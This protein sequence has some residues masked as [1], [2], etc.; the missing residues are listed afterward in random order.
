L[1]V[2]RNRVYELDSEDSRTLAVGG[3]F[4]VVPEHDLDV[5]HDTF[6]NLQDQRLVELVDL[7]EGER[8]LTLTT[9]ET[10]SN[11]T[12]GNDMMSRRRCSTFQLLGVVRQC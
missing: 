11:R 10:C 2:D 3:A 6:D 9:D 5:P 7:G 12:R 4:R 8:G 1:V